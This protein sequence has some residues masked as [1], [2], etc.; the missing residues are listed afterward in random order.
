METLKTNTRVTYSN[1][2]CRVPI[3]R[4]VPAHPTL[5]VD[6]IIEIEVDLNFVN[7]YGFLCGVVEFVDGPCGYSV[8]DE[9][10]ITEEEFQRAVSIWEEDQ[11]HSYY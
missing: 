7:H 6:A 11:G 4:R 5:D 2:D 9:I 10:G 3:I 8:G 1:V